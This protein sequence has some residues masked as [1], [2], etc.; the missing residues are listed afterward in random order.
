MNSPTKEQVIEAIRTVYD[1]EIHVNIYELGLIYDICVVNEIAQIKMTLTS[2]FCP[3]A[4]SLPSQVEFVVKE[5]PG[6]KDVELEI[7][8][9]PPWTKDMMSEEAKLELGIYD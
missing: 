8:W 9:D 6:I 4:E 2:A 7:V 5:I 3:A 1:P